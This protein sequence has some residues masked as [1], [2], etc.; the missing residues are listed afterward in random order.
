LVLIVINYFLNSIKSLIVFEV[1]AMVI[2]KWHN[3]NCL[4]YMYWK[5]DI[6]QVKDLMITDYTLRIKK[7]IKLLTRRNAIRPVYLSLCLYIISYGLHIMFA[8]LKYVISVNTLC[9]YNCYMAE[10]SVLLVFKV[11]AC[12]SNGKNVIT[13]S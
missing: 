8:I 1:V 6:F 7:Y 3:D 13:H 9:V 12:H 2:K 5:T 10:N 11:A 4:I